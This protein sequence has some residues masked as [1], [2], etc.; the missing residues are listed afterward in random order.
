MCT[1]SRVGGEVCAEHLLLGRF[2]RGLKKSR[3]EHH[4][5]GPREGERTALPA[6]ALRRKVMCDA[7]G[8]LALGGHSL[9]L[10]PKQ[11][12]LSEQ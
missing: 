7:L 12:N 9:R 3:S 11:P 10:Q 8:R 5:R 1:V 6:G 2:W 4:C